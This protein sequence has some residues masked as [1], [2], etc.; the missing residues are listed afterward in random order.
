MAGMA[1]WAVDL[2]ITGYSAMDKLWTACGQ[3]TGISLQAGHT[4]AHI[5]P[6][7]YPQLRKQPVT[8]KLHSPDYDWRYGAHLF[9]YTR[10]VRRVHRVQTTSLECTPR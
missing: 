6:T 10:R 3:Q 8:H 1:P 4:A 7:A 5:L 9:I 2:W